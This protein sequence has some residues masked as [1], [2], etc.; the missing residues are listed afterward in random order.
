MGMPAP[1]AADS[2]GGDA[3]HIRER[4]EDTAIFK[5]LRTDV[6]GTATFTFQLPDNITSWRITASGIS[7]T[8]YAG[9]TVQNL[10][11]TNPMFVHYTLGSTFLVG[12]TPYIGVNAFGTALAGGET[13][14]FEVWCESTPDRRQTATGAAFER[15]NIPLWEM[16]AEG[17]YALV[18]QATVGN[19]RDAVR[20]PYQV[21]T[22]HR[23]VDAAVFYTV[24]ADT[25]FDVNPGGLTN[26]TFTDHGRGQFLNGLL[27]L[28]WTRGARI[29]GL[30]ARREATRLI[31]THFPD[32]RLFGGDFD[33]DPQ[34]YQVESGGIAMLPYADADLHT[35]VMVMPFI[36]DEISVP[37]LRSYLQGIVRQDSMEN[38]MLALY[39]LAMLGE[40]VLLDL[41]NYAKLE[42]LSVRDMAYIALGFAALGETGSA[43]HLFNTGIAPHIQRVAPYYRINAGNNREENIDATFVAALLAAQLGLPQSLG[44]HNYAMRYRT[45]DIPLYLERLA[46]IAHEIENFNDE[47]ASI[48]YTI[49]GEEVTRNL[50]G[51]RQ[52]TLRIPAQNMHEFNIVSV[53]GSVGAVSIIRTPLEDME[54]VDN[55]ITVRREF[56]AAGSHTASTSFDQGDLVRVQITVNYPANAVSGSY[57]I[58]D[59]LPAGL[60]LVPNSAR[61]DARGSVAGHWRHARTEG[62]RVT[63]FDFNGRFTGQNV[64]YYYARVVSPGTFTAEGTMVQSVGA[65]EYL[66]VGESANMTI[67]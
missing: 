55:N 37:A 34:E 50:S 22:S 42:G 56:F 31:E 59:F 3:A 10:R 7:N 12:D 57:V 35:T 66:S 64:Y 43:Y 58:T 39:G 51:R 29:E 52:F 17:Q 8:L 18:V 16:A 62:Q 49:F 4:F 25:V 61:F 6:D 36:M 44:L 23:M 27:E 63:F 41:Q 15:V 2:G 65:R 13:V 28:R 21:I 1:A 40:P 45:W 67:R 24:T 30:V 20:H 14:T 9:N 11:V 46:F 60:V 26:I 53:T 38:R 32:T 5:S 33:F 19:L 54:P 48:T 47:A